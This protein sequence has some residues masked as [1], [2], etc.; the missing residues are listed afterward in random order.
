M[1]LEGLEK[2]D[3][4]YYM[5]SEYLKKLIV[6]YRFLE[7]PP[8]PPLI[9]DTPLFHDVL[10]WLDKG[11]FVIEGAYGVGKSSFGALFYHTSMRTKA[12]SAT[13]IRLGLLRD[14]FEG[15]RLPSPQ[16]LEKIINRTIINPMGVKRELPETTAVLSTLQETAEVDDLEEGLKQILQGLGRKN[17]FVVL[18]ESDEI[19]GGEGYEEI[20]INLARVARRLHDDGLPFLKIIVLVPD[21]PT[22]YGPRPY[23]LIRRRLEED[24][25]FMRRVYAY[26]EFRVMDSLGLGELE[27]LA[28]ECLRRL[29]APPSVRKAIR[30]VR[31]FRKYLGLVARRGT[32]R[33]RVLRVTDLVSTLAALLVKD[34]SDI[35]GVRD[36]LSNVEP[37]DIAHAVKTAIN[38]TAEKMSFEEREIYFGNYA[39]SSVEDWS[40][41]LFTLLSAL[42]RNLSN[43]GYSVRGPLLRSERRGF[44]IHDLVVD[45]TTISYWLRL[46]GLTKESVS[47]IERILSPTPETK[48]TKKRRAEKVNVVCILPLNVKSAFAAAIPFNYEQVILNEDELFSVFKAR[49]AQGA[50]YARYLSDDERFFYASALSRVEEATLKVIKSD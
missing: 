23:L 30:Y 45:G 50:D 3:A 6:S 41:A 5:V 25:P 24:D 42:S 16:E 28:V 48:N 37:S 10:R 43:K 8:E 34:A 13:Y 15:R 47:W 39:P 19:L 44:V 33:S 29:G 9:V 22:A 20:L 12:F 31:S 32:S 7:K 49:A 4:V 40:R 36:A 11:F 17:Y 21:T 26:S 14:L 46:T 18:D 1:S 27:R 35:K 38:I 2:N